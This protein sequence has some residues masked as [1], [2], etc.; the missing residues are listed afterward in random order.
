MI[1]GIQSGPATAGSDHH[2]AALRAVMSG[3]RKDCIEVA[4]T[5]ATEPRVGREAG[6]EV[7]VGPSTPFLAAG[8][9]WARQLTLNNDSR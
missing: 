5:D 7:V 2:G 9:E 3:F 1:R 4:E 6:M 8:K